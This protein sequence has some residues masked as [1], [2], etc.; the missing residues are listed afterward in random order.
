MW[1][2]YHKDEETGV[3]FLEVVLNLMQGLVV[4]RECILRRR[5]R[6]RW[7]NKSLGKGREGAGEIGN[8][9]G[10]G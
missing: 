8:R 7:K 10:T 6:S 4:V 9:M 5:R 3:T 1:L 2:G